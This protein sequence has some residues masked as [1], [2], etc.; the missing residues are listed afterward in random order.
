M[1][2]GHDLDVDDD[3]DDDDDDEYDD[4]DDDDDEY[5]EDDDAD[6]DDGDDDDDDQDVDDVCDSLPTIA[7]STVLLSTHPLRRTHV[8]EPQI[9]NDVHARSASDAHSTRMLEPLRL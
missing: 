4:H 8:L 5:G 2:D 9:F 6:D 3:D 7:N 1:S